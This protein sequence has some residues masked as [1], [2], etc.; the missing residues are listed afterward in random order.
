MSLENL[1]LQEKNPILKRWLYLIEGQLSADN[2]PHSRERD[3]FT[4]PEGYIALHEIDSIYEELLH[5]L[6]TE[7]ICRSLDSIIRIKAVQDIPPSQAIAFVFLLKQSIMEKL[8]PQIKKQ[9]LLDEWLSFETKIDMLASL[10]FN[11]Y[12]HCREK[13]NE[14]RMNEIKADRERAFRLLELVEAGGRK[15]IKA[16]E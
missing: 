11:V 16:T 13:V 8:Q 1:L 12:M 6:N 14:L 10:A 15:K 4:N 7:K 3:Q 5:E 2:V 9:Q